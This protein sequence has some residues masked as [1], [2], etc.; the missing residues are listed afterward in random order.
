MRKFKSVLCCSPWCKSWPWSSWQGWLACHGSRCRCSVLS[1]KM[2]WECLVPD[3]CGFPCVSSSPW[4]KHAHCLHCCE[5]LMKPLKFFSPSHSTKYLPWYSLGFFLGGPEDDEREVAILSELW[6]NISNSVISL[7]RQSKREVI[8]LRICVMQMRK[9]RDS[10]KRN[11][12]A[13]L[14]FN[15]RL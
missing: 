2:Q 15:V 14:R 5:A 4:K 12:N 3:A 6:R 11:F 13:I 7:V 8:H 9:R 10:R 1:A